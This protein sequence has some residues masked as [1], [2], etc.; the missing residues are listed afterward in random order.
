MRVPRLLVLLMSVTLLGVLPLPAYGSGPLPALGDGQVRAL[1]DGPLPPGVLGRTYTTEVTVYLPKTLTY[2]Q[3]FQ[4]T[5]QVVATNTEDSGDRGAL[6]DAEVTL[7]RAWKGQDEW[8]TLATTTTS[9]TN[10]PVYEFDQEARR[11]ATYRVVYD[12][13]TYTEGLETVT[14]QPDTTSKVLRARR[15]LHARQAEPR[16]GF[17]VIK[18]NVDPGWGRKP[19]QLERKTCS[20]CAWRTYDEVQTSSTG[21]Y[22]FPVDFPPRGTWFYRVKVK[23]TTEFVVS[24]SSQFRAVT[25]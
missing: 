24:Y 20:G 22:L 13:E 12:G 11:N 2:G 4:I 16:P 7:E 19:V 10:T 14:Y 6:Q 5:G 21:A 18:G 15:E 17:Y 9:D 8:T 23:A 3:S 25:Y 1:A